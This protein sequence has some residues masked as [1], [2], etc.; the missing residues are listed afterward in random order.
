[1]HH[2]PNSICSWIHAVFTPED[3]L[4]FGGNYLHSFAM[5]KQLQVAHIEEVTRV[6]QKFRFPFFTEMLW[7]LL[8]R[9]I[10]CIYGNTHLDLPEEEKRRLRL[11][12]GD[13]IDPNKEFLKMTGLSADDLS[14]QRVA[15]ASGGKNYRSH[16]HILDSELHGIKYVVMY[17]HHL[18]VKSWDLIP[19]QN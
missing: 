8:D 10:H 16:V 7:Y 3:S 4:V 17:L 1:M 5:E 19:M 2:I 18:P 6:P 14:S 15:G 13:N 12:K 11:E 9:Y